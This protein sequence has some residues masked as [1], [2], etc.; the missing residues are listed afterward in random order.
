MLIKGDFIETYEDGMRCVFRYRV[1][2]AWT[3][4]GLKSAS[5]GVASRVTSHVSF[6]TCVPRGISAFETPSG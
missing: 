2:S 3:P 4:N 5:L 1:G 6:G